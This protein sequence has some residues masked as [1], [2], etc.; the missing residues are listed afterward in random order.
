MTTEFMTIEH[1]EKRKNPL[2]QPG[3]VFDRID[4][5]FP[6]PVAQDLIW[7]AR[8]AKDVE[9]TT[10][11]VKFIPNTNPLFIMSSVIR[12]LGREAKTYIAPS[13]SLVP[14]IENHMSFP[15]VNIQPPDDVDKN[16]FTQKAAEIIK[17][18]E[19]FYYLQALAVAAES[20]TKNEPTGL[21]GLWK[22]GRWKT[23]NEASRPEIKMHDTLG[24]GLNLTVN[25][26]LTKLEQTQ[27]ALSTK[28]EAFQAISSG[29]TPIK[30][31]G[32]DEFTRE[33]VIKMKR[34][35]VLKKVVGTK[36]QSRIYRA[37]VEFSQAQA[38]IVLEY[39][40]KRNI[41][42]G[43][44]AFVSAAGMAFCAVN[45]LKP[46]ELPVVST[47]SATKTEKPSPTSTSM[48]EGT[49]LVGNNINPW[50]QECGEICSGAT[51]QNTLGISFPDTSTR[52]MF[53]T[54]AEGN[55]ASRQFHKGEWHIIYGA[56]APDGTEYWGRQIDGTIDQLGSSN[57][58]QV[59]IIQ[60]P[61]AEG[62]I[63]L[64]VLTD[65]G[66]TNVYLISPNSPLYKQIRARENRQNSFETPKSP[67]PAPAEFEAYK[68]GKE[69]RVESN[70]NGV[71]V[72]VSLII[73]Q[74]AL[75]AEV[76]SGGKE[77]KLDGIELNPDFK[78]KYG[79]NSEEA[80]AHA[81]LYAQWRA[82]Q[83]NVAEEVK[84]ER[85]YVSF[86]K[87]VGMVKTAQETNLQEDWDEVIYQASANDL[88]TEEYDP[89]YKDFK[90]GGNIKIVYTNAPF[91]NLGIVVQ[92]YEDLKLGTGIDEDGTMFLIVG[93]YPRIGMQYPRFST[94]HVCYLLSRL[95]IKSQ[96]GQMAGSDWDG[97]AKRGSEDMKHVI[98]TLINSETDYS[99][100]LK[101]K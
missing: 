80:L 69:T 47:A 96:S 91:T 70:Y 94:T 62:N 1:N 38:A 16:A 77:I 57:F 15:H 64:T 89:E 55:L 32:H 11:N 49:V 6:E 82:W 22:T 65:D 39:K 27:D 33:T 97:F 100:H 20:Q 28:F 75:D 93:G 99:I 10:I 42:I 74:T 31:I 37:D 14:T 63:F 18:A 48:P 61:D 68:V 43:A 72:T 29:L 60:K 52:F 9:G 3:S 8:A 85:Q 40:Q 90:P 78:N 79:E 2:Y 41:K 5:G 98:N 84:P 34:A 13:N 7:Y 50:L 66:K 45:G 21:K 87:W 56:T 53:F 86:D 83:E 54:D 95:S 36:L 59:L 26:L 88:A 73:D 81:V 76:K 4:R 51:E 46:P 19:R 24:T 12:D 67:E 17:T 101:T 58:E 23:N 44:G 25:D 71:D 30:V 92:N 35:P